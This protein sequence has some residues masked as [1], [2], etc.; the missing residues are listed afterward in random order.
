MVGQLRGIE[1]AIH[2]ARV[3]AYTVSTNMKFTPIKTADNESA[4]KDDQIQGKEMLK[5][6]QT[7]PNHE[8]VNR[9]HMHVAVAAQTP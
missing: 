3:A 4:S 7:C 8:S 1:R 2:W 9:S 5:N 6:L